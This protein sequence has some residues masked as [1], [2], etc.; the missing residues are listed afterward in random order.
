MNRS[1]KRIFEVYVFAFAF[2]FASRPLSDGDFW[3]HLKTGEYIVKTGLIPRTDLFSFTNYGIPWIAHGWLS[4]VIFYEVYSRLGFN[5]LIFIF[6]VLTALAFW[7]TYKL[8]NAHLFVRG[9]ATLLGVWTV[10]P[11]IG[12]RPRVFTLL[13][14]SVYLALLARYARE[15]KGRLIWLLVPL[16]VLWVNLHGAFLFGPAFIVFTIVGIPLDAWLAGEKVRPMWPRLTVL[17]LVLLGCILA[18]LVNP[19]GVGI[20]SE[21]IEILRSPVYQQVVVDWLSPNFH[22]PELLPLT[23]LVL[24]TIAALALSPK[25]ARPSE[26]LLF[27]AMLYSTLK[28]QRNAMV[29]ALVAVPLIA[30]YLQSWLQ[31]L[32]FGRMFDQAESPARG[33]AAAFASLL[34]LLPLVAF[35]DRLRS[36]VYA[37]PTQAQLQVPVKA[38]E[39]LKGKQITGNT[40]TDPNIWGGY[41]IW[42]LPSNPVYIDG[43]GLFPE[44]FVKEYVGIIRGV[45]DWHVPFDRYGVRVAIVV[46][47][48]PLGRQLKDSPDWQQVYEDEMS[49]VFT[50]R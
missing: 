34:L 14:A 3:F 20:Y 26:V 38:V 24:S 49:V 25:R 42:E 40:L 18:S 13:L 29:L 28:M 10:L 46:P 2:F 50:K 23:L 33:R 1:L 47:K 11:N 9:F 30:D 8:S 22:Q 16:M 21:T 5:A 39:Y 36:K 44:S 48:S 15:G 7:I 43:R 45:A 41:L 17:G 19:W 27:L 4:G 12:V 6:A 31:T 35:A 37:P 32:P